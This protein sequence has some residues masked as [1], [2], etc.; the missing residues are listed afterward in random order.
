MPLSY[1]IPDPSAEYCQGLGYDILVEETEEGQVGICKFPD[2]S[3]CPTWDFLQGKCGEDWSYC[4]QRGYEMKTTVIDEWS[5]NAVCVLPDGGEAEVLDLMRCEMAGG[6][7]EDEECKCP[8]DCTYLWYNCWIKTP[9]EACLELG[10]EYSQSFM[11]GP[12]GCNFLCLRDGED[13]TDLAREKA[14]LLVTTPPP[15][16]P[17]SSFDNP[18]TIHREGDVG[19]KLS[20]GETIYYKIWLNK[21]KDVTLVLDFGSLIDIVHNPNLDIYLYNPHREQVSASTGENW[22]AFGIDEQIE[23]DTESKDGYYYIKIVNLRSHPHY[24]P[25]KFSLDVDVSTPLPLTVIVPT[26]ELL[27]T[28]SLEPSAP[29][30]KIINGNI[31]EIKVFG[32]SNEYRIEI[33]LD[34]P[35]V[36]LYNAQSQHIGKYDIPLTFQG[37][38][39][40]LLLSFDENVHM[41]P[42][43]IAFYDTNGNQVEQGGGLL[44]SLL[45]DVIMWGL[46]KIISLPIPTSTIGTLL[47]SQDEMLVSDILSDDI[48]HDAK[49]VLIVPKR[50]NV[51]KVTVFISKDSEG[52]P[53][54]NTLHLYVK[55]SCTGYASG[56]SLADYVP[57]VVVGTKYLNDIPLVS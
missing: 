34:T 26:P 20:E 13:I 37:S 53:I 42:K 39:S 49:S 27:G 16:G 3:S 56:L 1:A 44:E 40:V 17:G 9:I 46:G 57:P 18:I 45:S 32:S 15:G 2:G 23:Y 7:W 51:K 30:S 43:G 4:K 6:K 5:S 41:N 38:G 31:G 50:S 55:A 54:D 25:E 47:E 8:G 35:V 52:T 10:G 29:G 24:E 33:E 48:T 14:E 21:E 12:V 19:D 11:V 22:D 28:Y 36:S